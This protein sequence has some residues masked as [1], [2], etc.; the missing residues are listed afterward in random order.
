V[1]IA[2][3]LAVPGALLILAGDRWVDGVGIAVVTLS[4]VPAIAGIGLLLSSL[5]SW[6]AARKKPFV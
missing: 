4:L 3:L 6:W 2:V 1:L 5:V